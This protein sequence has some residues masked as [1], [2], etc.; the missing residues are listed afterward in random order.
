MERYFEAIG[1][2][3]KGMTTISSLEDG[4]TC[5]VWTDLWAGQVPCQAYLKL[6]SFAKQRAASVYAVKQMDQMDLFFHLP[7]LTTIHL[8]LTDLLFHIEHSTNSMDRDVWGYI[9]GSPFFNAAK[10]YKRICGTRNVYPAFSW[11]WK[12]SVQNKHKV[13]FWLLLK[14]RL[15][16]RGL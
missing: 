9:W 3:Y 15:C 14:D 12:S 4:K 2:K 11:I 7:L 1:Y 5:Y 10:A 6:Y 13:L 8:Q 16:T